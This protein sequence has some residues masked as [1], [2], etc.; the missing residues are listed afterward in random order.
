VAEH[1]G[2]GYEQIA[3]RNDALVYCAITG[4][5]PRGPFAG[6]KGYE[7]IVGAKAGC[8][9]YQDRPRYAPIAGACF[10]ASQAALQG[11]L[12][13]LYERETSGLGQMVGASLVQGLTAYDLY[14]WLGSQD[15]H[16]YRDAMAAPTVYSPLQG[17]T[18]FTRDGRWLQFSNF[19]PALFEAFLRATGLEDTHRELTERGASGEEVL[20]AALR[21][22]HEK[23][24][25][26]WMEIFLDDPDIGV[27][28][29]RTPVESMDHPQMAENGVVVAVDDPVLG[30]TR[31]LGPLVRMAGTPATPGAGAPGLGTHSEATVLSRWEPRAARTPVPAPAPDVGTPRGPFSGVTIVELAWFYAAPF[32]LALLADLGARVIKVEGPAGDPHR[33]QN[34]IREYAGVKGLQGKESVVVDYRSAEGLEVL[35]RLVARADAVMC[36]YRLVDPSTSPNSYERLSASN[37]G[38]VYLY[39]AAYGSSGP[40]RTRPAFAPTMAVAAG[41]RAYQ[42]GWD[43][44]LSHAEDISFV[45]GRDR[46]AKI[47]SWSG[48]P[49]LNGDVN[50]ALAVGTALALGLL[51]RQRIGIGQY[52]ETTMLG[53]NA[54][55]VSEAWFECPGDPPRPR[56]DENGV[57]ALYR[58]YQTDDGWAFLAAPQPS[59]WDHLCRAVAEATAG[60]LDLAADGRFDDPT[61]RKRHDAALAEVIAGVLARA[62]AGSWERLFARHDI[63]CAE[64]NRHELSEFSVTSQCMTENGFVT[65]VEHPLFGRHRRHGVISTLTRTPGVTGPAPLLGQ[66]TRQVLAELGY[67]AEEMDALRARGVVD[68][69]TGATGDGR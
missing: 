1:L 4:F 62:S 45:E 43:R 37:P 51:A 39:A 52:M 2:L 22:L 7:A 18:G 65:E 38:L 24:F 25:D 21:R 15:R 68:W 9:A 61:S 36:N 27:E 5:G 55:A 14:H 31:Q 17:M 59:E 26:K 41:Q 16:R 63:A 10:G 28:V 20:E 46:L 33:Y 3:I 64:V 54:Y 48:G 30:P 69:P 66:Q 49:T 13:A 19:R 32:G 58:L 23:T 42:L 60:Q 47:G 11:I 8:F 34:A 50:P 44:A 67:S 12:G 35:D 29:F 6:M 56:H 57:G 40:Y 53:S